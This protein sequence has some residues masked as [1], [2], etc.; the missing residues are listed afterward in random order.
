MSGNDT[1]P[2]LPDGTGDPLRVLRAAD[3]P[4]WSQP[5]EPDP[6]FADALRERLIRGLT[7]PTGVDM[8]TSEL[9]RSLTDTTV[10]RP[11][12]LP[13]LTVGD[14]ATALDWYVEN[15]GARLRGAPITMP[16]GR[17][18]HAE[19]EIGGGAIYLAAEFPDMG[20]RAPTPGAVSVSLML[21]VDDADAAARR[22][23]AGGAT[24]ARAPYDAHGTRTA[25]IVDPFGH[26]WLLTG[27]APADPHGTDDPLRP[28]D[29]G[30]LSVN[31]HDAARARAFFHAV[32]GWEFASDGRHVSS[33]NHPVVVVETTGPA[34]MFCGYAVDDIDS[35]CERIESAG[36]RITAV[37]YENNGRMTADA[38]D[39]AGVEF[40]IYVASPEE[41][42]PDQ[43]PRAD[44]DMSYLTMHTRDS[45]RYRAF[46]GSVLGWRF[47][48]GRVADG[49]EADGPHPQIGVAG[50]TDGE[51]AVPMWNTPDIADAVA[52][53]RAAGGRVIT[54]P[55]RQAY[56]LMALC[57]DDQGMQFY[58]GELF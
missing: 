4:E 9:T 25:T 34:T 11:G 24:L 13:Y 37:P 43:Y 48:A 1:P 41:P 49:W 32:L 23:E 44:G 39:D 40:A 15:L 14:V 50:G 7:L 52:R 47:T 6:R 17:I 57:A 31:T 28:G 21:S 22:A 45:A 38:V 36:G 5:F 16:D 18:G 56:G 55:E 29:I 42:R 27:P 30:F 10:E 19:L 20:L 54:E 26:R 53:V 33:L 46:Y 3:M 12:A 2:P 35:A 8:N 51:S 58:L